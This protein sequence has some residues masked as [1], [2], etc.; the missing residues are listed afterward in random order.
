MSCSDQTIEQKI[1]EK[2][3]NAP[4]LTPDMVKEN[5]VNIDVVTYTSISGQIL[6]WSV[7]TVKSG[8]AVTGKPS[9]CI[10]PENDDKEIGEQIAI[11]NAMDEL[12]QLMG[13][14]FKGKL[15]QE[16]ATQQG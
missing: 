12:W 15:A 16:Q 10:S 8:F 3:L 14:E 1:Q 11:E 5:I 13:Y 6:R 2:G 7:I 4:R 9:V